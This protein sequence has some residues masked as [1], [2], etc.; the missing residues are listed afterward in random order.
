MQTQTDK[1]QALKMAF[2]KIMVHAVWGTKNREAILTKE[3]R[4]K[5]IEH[6]EIIH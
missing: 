1:K 3:I 2:V 5:V 4:G 6:I